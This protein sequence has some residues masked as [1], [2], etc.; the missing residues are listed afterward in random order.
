MFNASRIQKEGFVVSSVQTKFEL[1][2]WCISHITIIK[3]GFKM[4]KLQPPKI[5]GV[6]TLKKTNHQTNTTKVDS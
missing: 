1:L 4:K 6:E 2:S 3:N 5:K